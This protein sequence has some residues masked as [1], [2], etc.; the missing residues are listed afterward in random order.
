MKR[1]AALLLVVFAVAL[2]PAIAAAERPTLTLREMLGIIHGGGQIT[3]PPEW[4]GIWAYTDSS[5]DCGG[6]YTDSFAGEDTLCAGAAIF[7]PDD[8]MPAN[9][10]C[11]GSADATNVNVTCTGS[12]EVVT[13]CIFNATFTLRATRT[14]NTFYSVSTVS[15]TYD[16]T[17]L[18]CDFLP[19][20]CDQTNTQATRTGPAPPA[21]C[22][23]PTIPAS[24]G[25]L[26][27]R[28]R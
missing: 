9:F 28:Y 5:Y 1:L 2:F 23:T 21:Y 4:D 20:F 22:A 24:W 12:E 25:A 16:G 26:K 10:S 6:T 13:D 18:G 8:Q 14:G 7:E 19:D 15:M 17:G 11:S 27:I 3:I